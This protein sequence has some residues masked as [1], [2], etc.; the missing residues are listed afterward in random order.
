MVTIRFEEVRR[1][2]TAKFK[3]PCGRWFQRTVA[4]TQTISP[5]NRNAAGEIKSFAEIWGEVGEKIAALQPD[6]TCKCG[7]QGIEI[8]PN[9]GVAA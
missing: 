6:P 9:A 8:C 3:C 5:F 2:R 7:Q 4:A 1:S